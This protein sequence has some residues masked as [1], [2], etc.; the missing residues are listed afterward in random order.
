LIE[1]IVIFLLFKKGKGGEMMTAD[2]EKMR[3]AASEVADEERKYTSSVEEINGLITNKLAECWGDEAYDE[4]NKEYT[5]KSKPNLEE[6]GR[7]LKEFSNSL[8]TAA[9]DLDKAINSLR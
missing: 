6:L 9:D 5:S 1:D 7:L 4:L 3:N 2:T 8:N